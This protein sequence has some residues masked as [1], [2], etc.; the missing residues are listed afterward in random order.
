MCSAARFFWLHREKEEVQ[1]GNVHLKQHYTCVKL[2]EMRVGKAY[3][4]FWMF[5]SFSLSVDTCSFGFVVLFVR[6]EL[7]SNG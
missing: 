2:C 4:L 5:L 1:K 3:C 6:L 7:Y